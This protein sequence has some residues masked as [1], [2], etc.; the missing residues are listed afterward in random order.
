MTERGKRGKAFRAGV[1]VY[2]P[3]SFVG[4]RNCERRISV[5][6]MPAITSC[7]TRRETVYGKS[8][9]MGTR[10]RKQQLRGDARS[11]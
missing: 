10:T 11:L 7:C 9:W 8:H 4:V 1:T 3:V 2:E 6:I 5:T